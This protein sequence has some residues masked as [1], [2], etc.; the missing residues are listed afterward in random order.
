LIEGG[1]GVAEENRESSGKGDFWTS[2]FVLTV[3]SAF[4]IL[5]GI[6]FNSSKYQTIGLPVDVVTL[7]PP[8]LLLSGFHVVFSLTFT[9]ILFAFVLA[10]FFGAPIRNWLK[11]KS[12]SLLLFVGVFVVVAVFCIFH[13]ADVAGRDAG[14]NGTIG[15]R[16]I[17]LTYG[18]KEK[19]EHGCLIEAVGDFY[20]IYPKDKDGV[21]K[22]HIVGIPIGDIKGAKLDAP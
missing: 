9:A 14:N 17:E 15:C 5:V 21:D 22:Q 2:A 1:L 20:W 10:Y 7:P 4:L 8:R 12:T 3:G 19:V 11:R 16:K 18:E 6:F 13:A